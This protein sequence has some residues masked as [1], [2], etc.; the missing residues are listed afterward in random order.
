MS[1]TSTP[2]FLRIDVAAASRRYPIF[3]GPDLL[4]RQ[5]VREAVRAIFADRKV[6]LVSDD[7]VASLYA[8]AL[9]RDLEDIG[10][11]VIAV[12]TF[13]AG[14]QSKSM[15]TVENICRHAVRVG[16]DRDS[17]LAVLGGGVPGDVAGFAAAVYMR[18]IDFV[19]TPT[20]LL[21]MVDSS[22]GGKTGVDLPE[23]KN[24]VGAFHQPS[25]VLA[26]V[27]RLAT[28]PGR[29]LGSGLAE[30]VKYGAIM[31]AGFFERLEELGG[32]LLRPDPDLY[33]WIVAHCCRC[34]SRIVERDESETRNIREI[35]NYGHTFGHALESLGGFRILTH[36]EAVAVGMLMAARLGVLLRICPPEVPVRLERLIER[37]KLPVRAEL[38]G[39]T[40]EA[41]L[42]TMGKDKKVRRGRLRFVLPEDLGRVII[43]ECSERERILEAIEYYLGSA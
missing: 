9:R 29:Q 13:P 42:E 1:D 36:G 39:I 22:V 17:L 19:Q 20:S 38:P 32:Q 43:R 12:H 3:V 25:L 5:E 14:E 10:V 16:L 15:S 27:Q 4:Q 24:L 6:M 8:E 18:G 2:Q 31:D 11:R 40:A 7:T 30:V 37:L 33:T 35:L 41:V 21:A 34:K 23:G 26:D 28:L